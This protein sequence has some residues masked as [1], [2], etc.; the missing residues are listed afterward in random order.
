[1]Q[2]DEELIRQ[3]QT[4]RIFLIGFSLLFLMMFITTPSL[5][6]QLIV[7]M[8]LE[9]L[10]VSTSTKA[11]T[12]VKPTLKPILEELNMIMGII[13]GIAGVSGLIL[14]IYQIKRK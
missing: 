12:S 5:I 2:L 8:K 1:M 13:S 4:L 3:N 11:I 14:S 6:D 7:L 9:R 10:Q